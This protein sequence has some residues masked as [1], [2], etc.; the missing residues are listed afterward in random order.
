MGPKTSHIATLWNDGFYVV[1]KEFDWER[2]KKGDTHTT[3]V[4][5]M[6]P[7]RRRTLRVVRTEWYFSRE[8]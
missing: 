4:W 8:N 6:Q 7:F 2:G 1:Y 5:A 3:T